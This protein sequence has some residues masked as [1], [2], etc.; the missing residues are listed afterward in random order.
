MGDLCVERGVASQAIDTL[1][2]LICFNKTTA[3]Y[4]V[5]VVLR[6]VLFSLSPS[7]SHSFLDCKRHNNRTS[8]WKEEEGEEGV[9]GGETV[10]KGGNGEEKILEILSVGRREKQVGE[11]RDSE[12]GSRSRHVIM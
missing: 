5:H 2:R 10:W 8:V 1:K 6:S 12:E 4:I 9:G 3:D 11:T 7:L